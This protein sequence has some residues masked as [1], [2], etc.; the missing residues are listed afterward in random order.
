M[1]DLKTLKRACAVARGWVTRSVK[2]IQALDEKAAD[3]V[4]V[5]EAIADFDARLVTLDEAQRAVE[6]E[7]PDADLDADLNDAGVFRD[8][9][10]TAR[11]KASRLLLK[12]SPVIENESAVSEN[13]QQ[14]LKLPKLELPKF[15]GDIIEWQPFWDKFKATV[16]SSE[17]PVITKFTYLQSLLVGEADASI[18][19]YPSITEHVYAHCGFTHAKFE[20]LARQT[21]ES[22]ALSGDYER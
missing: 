11:K 6:M 12:L 18:F 10:K 7:L 22:C 17:L 15:S 9:A 16:D 13:G 19:S 3:R 21:L 5:E 14:A 4:D 1:A 8:K 20:K 2:T